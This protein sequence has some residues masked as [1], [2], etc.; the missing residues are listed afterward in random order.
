MGGIQI[1]D[2]GGTS[3]TVNTAASGQ[4][5]AGAHPLSAVGA[6]SSIPA[7]NQLGLGGPPQ[8]DCPIRVDVD[9]K[10][11]LR[12]DISFDIDESKRKEYE[13]GIYNLFFRSVPFAPTKTN[14]AKTEAFG[15]RA[16]S[17]DKKPRASDRRAIT[18]ANSVMRFMLVECGIEEERFLEAAADYKNNKLKLDSLLKFM[19]DFLQIGSRNYKIQVFAP[20][21]ERYVAASYIA[22]V[23]SNLEK[24]LQEISETNA[25]LLVYVLKEHT[26]L[27]ERTN[28]IIMTSDES[29]AAFKSW[30]YV[31]CTIAYATL[32]HYQAILSRS[33]APS[34]LLLAARGVASLDQARKLLLPDDEDPFPAELLLANLRGSAITAW[35]NLDWRKEGVAFVQDCIDCIDGLA[36]LLPVAPEQAFESLM[37]LAQLFKSDPTI[38]KRIKDHLVPFDAQ[39]V[40]DYFDG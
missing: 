34:D 25:K 32:N 14:K 37:E 19:Y 26:T 28:T 40:F 6:A 8:S 29:N 9:H 7:H 23:Q 36:S 38:G 5:S 16:I 4:A 2:G 30:S 33:G 39:K 10:G 27:S 17:K 13:A 18:Y 35:K 1:K 12:L 24:V 22:T 20:D 21:D 11:V 31:R 3:P 15:E